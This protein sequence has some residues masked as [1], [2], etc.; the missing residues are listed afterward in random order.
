MFTSSPRGGAALLCLAIGLGVVGYAS[1]SL[2]AAD[3]PAELLRV[4]PPA[5][6]TGPRMTPYLTAQVDRAWKQDDA[7]RETFARARTHEDIVRLQEDL[8]RRA[9]AIIGQLPTERTPLNARVVGTIP[10]DGY[11]IEKV[12][13]ESVPGLHVTALVYVPDAPA[14]PKPAVLV[15]CGHSPLGKAFLNYQLIA[16]R[17]AKRGYVVICWD[18][19]GQGERSQFW[20]TA[21]GR[22]RYNMVC[23]E[24]AILGNFA[25][26]TG[27][28]MTRWMVWDA[29]RVVDYLLTRADV[30]RTR[31]AITG[32]SGG[33]FQSLW[34][35]ALDTRL[36]VV[37]PSAFV[38]ALPARM[39]NRIFDDPDSDPEQDPFGLVSQGVDHAGLLLLA[40]PRPVHVS[41][42]VKDFFPIEGTRKTLREISAI[43]ARLGLADRIWLKEGY[44]GHAYSEENQISAFAFIDRALKMPVRREL[45][46]VK[47]LEPTA[48]QCTR[49]GQVRV[50]LEGRSLI[51]VMQEDYRR[52]KASASSAPS[53][54]SLTTQYR[55]DGYP[56]IDRWRV[57]ADDGLPPR[58]TIA[59]AAAGHAEF[60]G[61]TVNRYLVRHSERLEM[62]LLHL[63]AN[64]ARSGARRAVL[65][66]GLNGH[67]GAADWPAVQRHL[68]AGFDVV[69]F[70]LRGTGETRMPFAVSSELPE[71]KPTDDGDVYDFPTGSVLANHVYNALLTGRPYFLEA[72][73]DV[74]I[75][76]RFVQQQLGVAQVAVTS[77]GD[78]NLLARAASQ[79]LALEYVQSADAAKPIEWAAIVDEG[80]ELWPIQ[81]LM[82]GGAFLAVQPR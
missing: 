44:H 15:A 29:M 59:W 81:Y 13:F 35:G 48:L 9:L 5:S 50:D 61:V 1:V 57:V 53:A 21:R 27:T 78:A 34:M 66:L 24:H 7:R 31:L 68:A 47:T 8:R 20:D 25:T 11:R 36:A 19:V 51:E 30:D 2:R 43:Y 79:V 58:N 18:P 56:G 82:P 71:P 72:I 26:L 38:T 49:S 67:I 54:S 12:I 3:P 77:Q 63:R 39:A 40:Y 6:E 14:G 22:S 10:M 32:T 4:R 16:G 33:G 52:R 60:E 69:S 46:P 42:A 17:L 45:D 23:G 76:T 37:A 70:D 41:A 28:S 64:A 62:P 74:E 73:E 75:A 65:M 55:G 80:R